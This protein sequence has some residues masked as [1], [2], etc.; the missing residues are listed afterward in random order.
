MKII[1]VIVFCLLSIGG[2]NH[3]Q[4]QEMNATEFQ[5]IGILLGWRFNR[6]MDQRYAQVTKKMSQPMYGMYYRKERK[7]KRE[8]LRFTMS[9]TRSKGSPELL[10]FKTIMPQVS[11]SHQRKVGNLWIGGFLDSFTLL[12]MPQSTTS[13]FGNNSISY[14]I[15]G[16]LGPMIGYEH[17]LLE[18]TDN[19][20]SLNTNA[21]IGLLNYVV[22][23]AYGHPYPE[24]YLTEENFSPT[25][26]DMAGP[27]LKSGKLRTVNNYQMF[28][29]VLGINYYHK[30]KIKLGLQYELYGQNNRSKVDR[31]RTLMQDL[32]FGASYLY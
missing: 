3:L 20:L 10:S 31:S 12:N 28:R 8:E 7:Q 29:F 9:R 18:N 2:I 17:N 24:K 19:R 26:A 21:R 4:A 15:V 11:Y 5:E 32:I 1:T 30:G 27:L 23:P 14:T 25:R 13:F 22:R 6:V 16:G